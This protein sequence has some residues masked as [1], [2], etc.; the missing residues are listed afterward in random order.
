MPMISTLNMW[1]IK[2]VIKKQEEKR[3]MSCK[4]EIFCCILWF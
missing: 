4:K 2:R 1:K 3:L